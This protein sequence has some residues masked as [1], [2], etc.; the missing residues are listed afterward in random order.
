MTVSRALR[1]DTSVVE[2][3]RTR[4]RALAK[5]MNYRPDPH[6]S[7]F[8]VYRNRLRPLCELAVIAYLT[9]DETHAG[10]KTNMVSHDTFVGAAPEATFRPCA[11][12]V[13]ATEYCL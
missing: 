10:F 9:A 2:R 3:V 8:V 4:V 7:A 13:R 1:E 5:E 11:S 6:L 12:S